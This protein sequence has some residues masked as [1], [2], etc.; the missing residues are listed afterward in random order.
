MA[1]TSG[2]SLE[3]EREREEGR[4]LS[5]KPLPSTIL[6]RWILIFRRDGI[7]FIYRDAFQTAAI[8]IFRSEIIFSME[9]RRNVGEKIQKSL[10]LRDFLE[11]SRE[12]AQRRDRN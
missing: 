6:T 3:E 12:K 5:S 8:K 10:I 9:K 11:G 1:E 4:T 2:R 7:K